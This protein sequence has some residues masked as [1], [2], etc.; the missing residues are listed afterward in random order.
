[1]FIKYSIHKNFWLLYQLISLVKL[2]AYWAGRVVKR[3]NLKNLLLTGTK[4]RWFFYTNNFV[5][6]LFKT[7]FF[8]RI[9]WKGKFSG[10]KFWRGRNNYK[11]LDSK[12]GFRFLKYLL[13]YRYSRNILLIKNPYILNNIFFK[14]VS[15]VLTSGYNFVKQNYD[16]IG[17]RSFL[18]GQPKNIIKKFSRKI[19]GYSMNLGWVGFLRS[20][21]GLKYILKSKRDEI[22][23]IKRQLSTAKSN[24]NLKQVKFLVRKLNVRVFRFR[25]LLQFIKHKVTNLN[26]LQRLQ[27][28]YNVQKFKAFKL[29]KF[30][31]NFIKRKIWSDRKKIYMILQGKIFD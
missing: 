2:R 6:D 25:K 1:L 4:N 24:K 31:L 8:M 7:N 19:L 27:K 29:N 20:A 17:H 15:T 26:L 16:I 23:L 11:L 3:F 9:L 5:K 13:L 10:R 30:R 22:L 21:V 14:Y 28:V 18:R 12:F